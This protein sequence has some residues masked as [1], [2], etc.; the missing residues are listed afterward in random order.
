MATRKKDTTPSLAFDGAEGRVY[1]WKDETGKPE[2]FSSVTTILKSL[3]H[4]ALEAWKQRQLIKSVI[5]H[6]YELADLDDDVIE[7]TLTSS[8]FGSRDTAGNVGSAVHS[9]IEHITKGTNTQP[10]SEMAQEYIHQFRRFVED[11]NPKF[12]ENEATVFS[13]TYGYAGTMDA[14]VEIDGV[15]YILDYKTGKNV[16]PEAALQISAYA[17]ADFIGRKNGV[18]DPLP[19]VKRGL[20]LHIRPDKYAL[21][22]AR[23]ARP[24]F[25]TFLSVL[26]LHRWATDGEHHVLGPI[27]EPR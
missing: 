19:E 13:R 25:E 27:I 17:R 15:R 26:D 24:T 6:K 16:Y 8:I 7:A 1:V 18:E 9:Y 3:P 23:I 10:P 4:P 22:Y 11:F 14:M 21:H 12:I 2:V 20:I 5:D